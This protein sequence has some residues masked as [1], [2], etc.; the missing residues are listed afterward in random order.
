MGLG[1]S[2]TTTTMLSLVSVEYCQNTTFIYGLCESFIGVGM[3]LGPALG[4]TL[5]N[6][7]GYAGA[8]Y[9]IAGIVGITFIMQVIFVPNRLNDN[10]VVQ[11]TPEEY[12]FD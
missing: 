9:A 3:I 1:P 2:F 5:Y 11:L 10:Y 12:E 4:Q 7:L 8:F 6:W